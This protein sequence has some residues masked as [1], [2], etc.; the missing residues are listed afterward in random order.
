MTVYLVNW[1]HLDDTCGGVER[2]YS[3]LAKAF[4]EV[5][6][7]SVHKLTHGSTNLDIKIKTINDYLR[8]NTNENDVVLKDAG[9]GTCKLKAK[10]ILHYG[11]PYQSLIKQYPKYLGVPYWQH[12]IN[13][14]KLDARTADICISNSYF[15]RYDAELN[16][17]KIDHII[18]NGV[19]INF[20]K[21]GGKKKNYV[22]W[23]GSKFKE[24]TLPFS[25]SELQGLIG[26]PIV[27]V[28][29]ENGLTPEQLL[30]Y[31]QE[32][33]CYFHPFP[34]EGNSNA[35]LEALSCDLPVLTSLCGLFYNNFNNSIGEY[36]KDDDLVT[37]ASKLKVL[38]KTHTQYESRK[39]II[40]NKLTADDYIKSM[41]EVIYAI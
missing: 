4:Q 20:W 38:I 23:V 30:P 36:I 19:N 37:I 16:G 33:L 17:C 34:I 41:Q 18:H 39:Y 9:V 26:V 28:Y 5:E 2:Q 1:T 8:K 11:N 10:K 25:L 24:D 22:L 3:I 7:V 32:A 31:Y 29:K 27:K 6:L 14:Q 40:D 13:A 35:I 21:P 12:L 15:T